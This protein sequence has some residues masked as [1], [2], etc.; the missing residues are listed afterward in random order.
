VLDEK[1][2]ALIYCAAESQIKELDNSLWSYGKNKFIPHVT[3][4]DNNFEFKNQPILISNQEENSNNANY[5]ILVDEAQ[6]GFVSSFSR[7]FYFYDSAS[8]N[9]AK[10]L[11]KKYSS[12][13]NKTNSFKKED[14]KWIKCENIC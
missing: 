1:K 10:Q 5:L 9:I 12:I 2:T 8:Q 3:I 4:F 11:A 14:G 6:T 13:T 7:V